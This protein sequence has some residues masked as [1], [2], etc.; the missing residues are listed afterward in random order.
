MGFGT[1]ALSGRVTFDTYICAPMKTLA[2]HARRL[3]RASRAQRSP[4][5]LAALALSTTAISTLM[6]C[7]RVQRYE[8]APIAAASADGFI[9]R[10]LDDPALEKFLSAQGAGA[11]A[12]AWTP[13]ELAL[14]ALYFHPALREQA[15]AVAVA[16]AEELTAGTPPGVSAS[17]EVSRAARVD[18]GKSTPWSISLTSGLMF[19]TGGKRAA[20][21]ARARAFTLAS[22]C[23][24]YTSP[25]P[26][27]G[28]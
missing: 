10:R 19:E 4:R 20:R 13:S 8:A 15:A 17:A 3:V 12:G 6:S 24:L 28:L 23:L 21:R 5:A 9:Q 16:R 1:M 7:G 26:R 14:A 11:A 27:D 22:I 18:E 2:L 25:S